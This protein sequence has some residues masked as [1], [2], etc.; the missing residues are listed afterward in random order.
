[1]AYTLL[2]ID[3]ACFGTKTS[4][5]HCTPSQT[6]YTFANPLQLNLEPRDTEGLVAN[7]TGVATKYEPADLSTQPAMEN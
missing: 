1:M 3:L 7:F 5:D 6:H 2:L 4:R